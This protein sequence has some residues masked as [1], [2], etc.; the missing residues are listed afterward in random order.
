MCS[1]DIS[2]NLLGVQTCMCGS[3][4]GVTIGF[5]P[6][7][8]SVNE[9]LSVEVCARIISGTLETD[10]IVT[11]SSSNGEAEGRHFIPPRHEVIS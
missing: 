5:D 11:L 10:A 7:T 3:V 6:V 9:G 1:S 8:Y 4:P 2:I